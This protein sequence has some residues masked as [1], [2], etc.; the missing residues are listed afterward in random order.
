MKRRSF[1]Q[2]IGAAA[3]LPAMPKIASA[4]L[5]PTHAAVDPALYKWAE[6]IVRAHNQSSTGMLQRLLH[7]E[8]ANAN[9]M[10]AE[11]IKQGVLV[12]KA[13]AFGIH[14]A[15]KPLYEGAFVKP[16]NPEPQWAKAQ[17]EQEEA[18][19]PSIEADEQAM[20]AMLAAVDAHDARELS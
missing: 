4:K 3:L 13:N 17:I 7:M 10:Q 6:M 2:A 15:V 19:D 20:I 5:A 1:L 8:A 14:T 11:L 12:P 9:A 16:H 18:V